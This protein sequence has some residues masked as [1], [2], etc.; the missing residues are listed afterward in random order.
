[1][2]QSDPGAPDH[3]GRQS[4]IQGLTSDERF[5]PKDVLG[6]AA[7]LDAGLP[8][9]VFTLVYTAAG[10]N[11]SLSLWVALGAG[12]LL[13]AVRLL[14]KEP[15]QNV[16]A[17]FLGVGLAAFM[18][19]RTGNAE[20]VFLPGL[21]I[22]IGYGLAYLVSIVVR[23]PLLGVFVGLATGQGT[24]WRKDPALLRA[25]TLASLLWVGM[26]AVRLAV[27]LPLY[28]AGEEQIGWLAGARLVMSWPLFLLVAY[29]SWLIIRPAYRAH[30]ERAAAAAAPPAKPGPVDG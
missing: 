8:L 23:W 18:A 20:D 7:L 14:R 2:S 3:A 17:G 25:Y 27:Q 19:N 6:P 21:L 12:V 29:L 5:R 4:W 26:F 9:A 13:A 16:V 1:M 30:Q 24:V 11:L 10:R 15:L 22:N 28:L